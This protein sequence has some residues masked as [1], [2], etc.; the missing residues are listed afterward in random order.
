M[1]VDRDEPRGPGQNRRPEDLARVNETSGQRPGRHA[2]V[3]DQAMANIEE[4]HVEDLPVVIA[5]IDTD[6]VIDVLAR[7]KTGPPDPRRPG[8]TAR[9]L[10]Y[11]FQTRRE[12]RTDSG[13]LH[14]L[15]RAARA[16]FSQPTETLEEPIGRRMDRG[17]TSRAQTQNQQFL[18]AEGGCPGSIHDPAQITSERAETLHDL[19]MNRVHERRTEAFD[20]S[21]AHSHDFS[22]G[23]RTAITEP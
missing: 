15:A 6:M 17:S 10:E 9:N 2:L 18:V 13:D 11:G 1:V 5:K 14:E 20:E 12:H 4:E 19:T 7:A 3:P 22:A 8:V 16:E 23:R 21:D